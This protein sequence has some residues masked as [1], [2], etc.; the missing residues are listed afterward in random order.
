MRTEDVVGKKFGRLNVEGFEIEKIQGKNRIHS[1]VYLICKCECGAD[2]RA[3][4]DSVLSGAIV[5]CGC[6]RREKAHY[7]GIKHAQTC[8]TH[9]MSKTRLYGI[10]RSMKSRCY[11]KT[12]GGFEYYGGR[13]ITVCNE[14]KNDFIAFK[15]W[16]INNG[17]SNNLSIDR[18]N[19]NGNY[20]PS[21]CRWIT[22][23]EQQKNRRNCKAYKKA[24]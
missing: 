21:N 24:K 10:W 19:V 1:R 9:N 16:A 2:V 14:W 23:A 8:I 5:S 17:Y 6:N 20:E 13:G 18:I 4:K 3:R 22:M 11:V 12:S 7:S 15:D